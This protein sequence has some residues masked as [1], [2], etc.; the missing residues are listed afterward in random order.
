MY[1]SEHVP[2]RITFKSQTQEHALVGGI[3]LIACLRTLCLLL[4]WN[5]FALHASLS[6]SLGIQLREGHNMVVA[7]HTVQHLIIAAGQQ[8]VTHLNRRG[9]RNL[10]AVG[11][12]KTV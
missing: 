7:D 2:R 3:E 1:P 8:L 9:K 11:N 4:Q 6:R 12:T 10:L 5:Q